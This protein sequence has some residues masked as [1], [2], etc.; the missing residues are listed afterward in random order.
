MPLELF[1]PKPSL[2]TTSSAHWIRREV[3]GSGDV[4]RRRRTGVEVEVRV[5]IV[6]VVG[7]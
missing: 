6:V 4:A 1:L 2:S 5:V 3:L 7:V